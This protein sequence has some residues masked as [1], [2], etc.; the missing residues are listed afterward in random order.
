MPARR[1]AKLKRSLQTARAMVQ[2]MYERGLRPGDHYMSE[3]EGIA[4]HGV[5]RGTYREALRFLEMQGVIV[6]RAGPAGGV[7]IGQPDWRNLASTIALLMQFSDASLRT[8]LEARSAI[9][10]GMAALA[11]RHATDAEVAD[12]AAMLVALRESVGAFP[13]WS[14]R[15]H[16]YWEALATSSH[17]TLFA[18]LSPA[19]R[20]IVNSGN[21]VPDE[22]YR[23][24]TQHR[25]EAV[26]AAVTA[27]D[28]AAAHAAM[29]DLELEF[30][31]RLVE[32]YPREID[33][34]VQWSEI[35]VGEGAAEE[36]K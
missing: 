24:A 2:A 20:S 29:L 26:H 5:S 10:P 11:A 14:R 34:V 22:N 9:E 23:L 28:E 16:E 19:L 1:S 35:R 36:M 33:R 32:G 25:L 15:Y 31:R 12:M 21:F 4:A 6:M 30:E 8:I 7:E 3:A 13:V 17:N 27:R 18:T